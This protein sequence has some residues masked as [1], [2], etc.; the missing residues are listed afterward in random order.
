MTPKQYLKVRA[1]GCGG[2]AIPLRGVGQGATHTTNNS[3]VRGMVL[4]DQPGLVAV[5][6]GSLPLASIPSRSLYETNT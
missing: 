4:M 3:V 6:V 2:G 5:E 1:G